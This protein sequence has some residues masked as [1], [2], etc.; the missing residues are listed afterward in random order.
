MAILRANPNGGR[1]LK[2]GSFPLVVGKDGR[3]GY[4]LGW[5]DCGCKEEIVIALG[6]WSDFSEGIN[7]SQQKAFSIIESLKPKRTL[8]EWLI[9]K[10]GGYSSI[11]EKDKSLIYSENRYFRK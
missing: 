7:E 10:L 1:P 2:P 4:K 5:C 6:D 11:P 3:M 9:E 8:R